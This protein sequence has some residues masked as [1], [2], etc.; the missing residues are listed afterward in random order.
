MACAL[1]AGS[2]DDG[3]LG[4]R[5]DSAIGGEIPRRSAAMSNA[6]V[7][8]FGGTRRRPDFLCE[9]RPQPLGRAA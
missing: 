6:A 8:P 9:R 5:G 2:S 1:A 4:N 3:V 7:E